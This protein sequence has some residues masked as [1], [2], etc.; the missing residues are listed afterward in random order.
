MGP[1]EISCC[2]RQAVSKWIDRMADP[3]RRSLGAAIPTERA[4][5]WVDEMARHFFSGPGEPGVPALLRERLP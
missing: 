1:A 5:R 2:A 3:H 4:D